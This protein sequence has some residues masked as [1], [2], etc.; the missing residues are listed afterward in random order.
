MQLKGRLGRH[1]SPM[2]VSP[3]SEFGKDEVWGTGADE[4]RLKRGLVRRN[5]VG[6]R[7]LHGGACCWKGWG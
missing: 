5:D 3:R 7:R 1:G 2:A 4:S 6:R